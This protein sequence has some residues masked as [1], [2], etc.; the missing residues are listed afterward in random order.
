MT[1]SISPID[2]VKNIP[3][4][5]EQTD[6]NQV[7]PK[8]IV[9]SVVNSSRGETKF[10]QECPKFIF[11]ST[12]SKKRKDTTDDYGCETTE[13]R[14][15]AYTRGNLVEIIYKITMWNHMY[16]YLDNLEE[17][18]SPDFQITSILSYKVD[19]T[20]NKNYIYMQKELEKAYNKSY[21]QVYE[22]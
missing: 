12:P 7:S 20:N 21:I 18:P 8:T 3:N 17:S 11:W 2:V 1:N 16:E 19:K 6:A 5:F 13:N 14:I 4:F 10:L 22:K 9:E 15:F